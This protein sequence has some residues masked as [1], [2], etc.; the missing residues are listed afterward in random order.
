MIYYLHT[1]VVKRFYTLINK[2]INCLGEY[3]MCQPKTARP[4]TRLRPT[5]PQS[6]TLLHKTTTIQVS[7]FVK[8]NPDLNII[9]SQTPMFVQAAIQTPFN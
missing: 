7:A 8:S 2:I 6:N 3:F 5:Q 1:I 4:N 9:L